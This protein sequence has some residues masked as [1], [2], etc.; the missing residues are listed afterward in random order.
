[1]HDF[2]FRYQFI[3][4]PF[5]A[6]LTTQTLKFVFDLITSGRI[7]F[8]RLV[9]AGGMPSSHSAFVVSLAT[10]IGVS[11]GLESAAFGLAVAFAL[12]VMYDAAG[13]RRATGKQAKVLNRMFHHTKGDFHLEEELKELI[14][15]TP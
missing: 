3:T 9:G 11:E 2:I 13:V 6:W 7:D 14:G 5:I 8:R 1:M 4:I 10:V 15:H 12:V